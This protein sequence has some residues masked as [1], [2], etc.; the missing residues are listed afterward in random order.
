[1]FQKEFQLIGQ[2]Q[3]KDVAD[4]STTSRTSIAPNP[5]THSENV[6]S[7]LECFTAEWL[8]DTQPAKASLQALRNP[9]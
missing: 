1:M 3:T 4:W 2:R 8:N 9:H 7:P 5:M 6:E